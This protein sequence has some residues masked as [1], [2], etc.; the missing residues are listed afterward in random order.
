MTCCL[1]YVGHCAGLVVPITFGDGD[2]K[3]I[4]ELHGR[5]LDKMGLA[6]EMER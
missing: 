1:D 2:K 3:E 5:L 4:C 6:M